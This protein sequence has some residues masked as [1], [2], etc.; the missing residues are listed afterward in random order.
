VTSEPKRERAAFARQSRT[1]TV[2]PFTDAA[3]SGSNSR[4]AAR[5]SIGRVGDR[6]AV[7]RR[8]GLDPGGR[9]DHVARD[10][11]LALLR[12]RRDSHDRLAGVDTNAHLE[13]E[14]G[15]AHV[16][17]VDRLQD[18][19]PGSH[20]SLRVVLVRRG[21]PNT[22]LTALPTNF[23]TVPPYRSISSRRRDVVGADACAHVLRVLPIGGRGEPHWVAEQHG[24]DLPLLELVCR[25]GRNE[26]GG[27]LVAELRPARFSPP[28]T[29]QM[30]IRGV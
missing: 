29:E 15:I 17:V 2:L 24:D 21:G 23:S 19:Q 6:H 4:D 26:R 27:A 5:R 20:R 22:A 28:H 13:V 9:V 25:C 3:V 14:I 7:Y 10:D 1:G 12:S 16:Q 18:P 11:A 30:A 8:H